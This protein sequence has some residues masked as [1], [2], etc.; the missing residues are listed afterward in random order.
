MSALSR[1]GPPNSPVDQESPTCQQGR[2]AAPLCRAAGAGQARRTPSQA[3]L[4]HRGIPEKRA[5]IAKFGKVHPHESLHK[6][7]EVAQIARV[8]K[9]WWR[10]ERDVPDVARRS[11]AL[12]CDSRGC[13][14]TGPLV[15]QPAVGSILVHCW[16]FPSLIVSCGPSFPLEGPK[17][18]LSLSYQCSASHYAVSPP[19]MTQGFDRPPLRRS[20]VA[21]PVEA[22]PWSW[23]KMGLLSALHS[24]TAQSYRSL[25]C[26]IC[27]LGRG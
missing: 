8:G 16:R 12:F 13:R 14:R 5:Q 26:S 24:Y 27:S 25:S 3:F 7:I 2:L 1:R 9:G 17:H 21:G 11:R 19:A 6:R 15:S 20:I 18:G 10:Q 23:I 22:R 4:L